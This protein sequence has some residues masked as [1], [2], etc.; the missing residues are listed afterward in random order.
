VQGIAGPC[1]VAAVHAAADPRAEAGAGV[2]RPDLGRIAL[3]RRIERI[4]AFGAIATRWLWPTVDNAQAD[5]VA[6]FYAAKK[7]GSRPSPR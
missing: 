3:E 6:A 7:Q 2:A 5:P 1:G 4:K